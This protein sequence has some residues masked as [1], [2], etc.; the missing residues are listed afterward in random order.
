EP[1]VTIGVFASERDGS[2]S[3]S[4]TVTITVNDKNDA[5]TSLQLLNTMVAADS[6]GIAIGQVVVQDQDNDEYEFSVDD[7]RL[8]IINNVLKVKDDSTIPESE[9]TLTV[10]IS[11]T[12]ESGDRIAEAF[13]LAVTPPPS[14]HHNPNEPMDANGDGKVSPLDALI[15][16]DALN[17]HPGGRLPPVHEGGEPPQERVDV[18][19]DGYISAIDALS[20]INYLNQERSAGEGEGLADGYGEQQYAAYGPQLPGSQLPFEDLERKEARLAIDLE[21]ER[22]LE[23][24]ARARQSNS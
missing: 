9:Q 14:P 12:S 11:A 6:A 23:E 22:L 16:I 3:V 8:E 15:I 19:N 18:N 24:L 17:N 7:G 21:L 1:Q 2:D 20:I 4:G 13:E 10:F 5:P